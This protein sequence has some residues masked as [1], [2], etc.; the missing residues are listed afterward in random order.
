MEQPETTHFSPII[1]FDGVC[2]FCES[3]VRFI[4]DR[5]P[6]GVFRF[7]SL[8]SEIGR[9]LAIGA[10]GDPDAMNTMMLLED[11]ELYTRST[12][13]LRI[14][15]RMRF[16]WRLARVF[17]AIPEEMRDPLYALVSANRYRWFGKKEECMIPS[18]EIR[19]RFLA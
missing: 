5:D 13:A 15:R 14:A 2:N 6:R 12:A 9:E 19:E 1:L 17:L 18:P 10:G 8:Q 3:S 4:V 11:G 7:A 16:P